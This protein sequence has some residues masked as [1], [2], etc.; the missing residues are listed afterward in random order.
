[1]DRFTNQREKFLQALGEDAAIIFSSLEHLRNGDA[2]FP[3]R[4]SSDVLYL[5][6]WEQP[7][8]VLLFRPQSPESFV[9]FVQPKER[10]REIW[11]GIRPG[12][13]G[14][15]K[16]YGAAVAY[17]IAELEKRLPAL[18]Q[19]YKTLHH[20]FGLDKKNDKL[21]RKAIDKSRRLGKDHGTDFPESFYS[22]SH[23]LHRQRL[24][25]SQEEIA[26]LQRAAAITKDAHCAAM[27]VTKPGGFEYQLEA[28]LLYHFRKMGGVGPGYTPIVGGGSN[29]VILH[30]IENNAELNDGDLVCVDAGCE[31]EWYTADVTR[32]WPVNGRFS[33]SQTKLYN[34][35]LK[36]LE[37]SIS[38][39][40]VGNQ[41][42]DVHRTAVRS[43]TESLVALGFLDGDI[44][45]LIEEEKYKKWF[46]HG[47]SHWLGL[48]VHDVGAYAKSGNSI[49]LEPGMV[50]TIEPGLYV[51]EGDESAPEEFRG[52][53][54]RIEDDILI[55]E[56]G[57]INLTE[58]VPKT[59]AEIEKLMG[60]G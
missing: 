45:T 32:T 17:P 60:E 44:D 40:V 51:A 49:L 59:I 11:T 6:G 19:G 24:Y 54:I 39:S 46:M 18:L 37:A 14:A 10:S 41:F 1:M 8:A 27:K 33:A 56:D 38:V 57:P 5:S 43:L 29:A 4:Q 23:T 47:T 9:M 16:D 48:D 22:L 52:M 21:L 42:M 13:E 58:A 50:F 34:A 28:E 31:Y 2:E 25:K 7:E 3:Y 30:Y 35:V 53:G 12:P 15:M 26:V 36:A 20:S 55:S